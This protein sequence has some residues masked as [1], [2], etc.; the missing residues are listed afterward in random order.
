VAFCKETAVAFWRRRV[1]VRVK[2]VFR[3]RLGV[4]TIYKAI[5]DLIIPIYFFFSRT[6]GA[7]Y[8]L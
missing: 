6:Q 4:R 2:E 1:R 7:S 5:H 8:K 3:K